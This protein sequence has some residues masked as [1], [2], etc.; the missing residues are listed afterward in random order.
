M[1]SVVILIKEIIKKQNRSYIID[2]CEGGNLSSLFYSV[3]A[4]K[5]YADTK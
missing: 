3:K 4:H 5:R 2:S 1:H